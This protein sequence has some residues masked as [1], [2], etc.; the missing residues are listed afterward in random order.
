MN[1]WLDYEQTS[2]SQLLGVINKT[3]GDRIAC[4]GV[5]TFRSFAFRHNIG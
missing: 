1:L 5:S 3:I 2:F 4:G